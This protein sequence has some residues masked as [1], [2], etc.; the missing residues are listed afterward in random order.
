MSKICLTVFII[1]NT[2]YIVF[3]LLYNPK[4]YMK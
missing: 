3:Y 1:I 4:H 2:N